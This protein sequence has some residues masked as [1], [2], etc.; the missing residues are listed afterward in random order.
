LVDCSGCEVAKKI[1]GKLGFGKDKKG[2]DGQPDERTEKEKKADVKKA[3]DKAEKIMKKKDATPDS[4]KAKFPEIQSKYKLTSIE[5]IKDTENKYHVTA[6]INPKD[7]S[8]SLPLGGTGGSFKL[9]PGSIQAHEGHKILTA[10]GKEKAIHLISRHGPD[11]VEADMK[12]RLD[13]MKQ[14]FKDMRDA[15]IAKQQAQIDSNNKKIAELNASPLPTK[16]ERIAERNERIVKLN[17]AIAEA[18]AL[19]TQYLSINDNDR[20]AVFD[21]LDKWKP[22]QMATYRVTKFTN[23]NT[24]ERVIKVAVGRK[25]AEIDAAFIDSS[26]NPKQTG[27]SKVISHKITGINLGKGYELDQNM[28]LV[29][30]STPLQTVVLS[31][32]ISGPFEYMVETAYLEP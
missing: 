2:K 24:M 5:L 32:V 13:K 14:L 11:V 19:I 27:T 21:T 9:A 7:D 1:G 26:G 15:K 22:P 12:D 31:L 16:P 20:T 8:S 25:Q 23:L 29:P 17:S 4:V 6:T 10:S 3:I 28:Q 18:Q 30:M